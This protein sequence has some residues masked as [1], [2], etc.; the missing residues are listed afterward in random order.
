MDQKVIVRLEVICA[1]VILIA[2]F[3]PWI[4]F[5]PFSI[6]GSEMPHYR[7]ILSSWAKT[8]AG[9]EPARDFNRYAVYFI[10]FLCLAIAAISILGRVPEVRAVSLLLSAGILGCLIFVLA[11]ADLVIFRVMGLGAY[12]TIL[13]AFGLGLAALG[14]WVLPKTAPEGACPAPLPLH[15]ATP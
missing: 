6:S 5:G 10:P 4:S 8:M 13:G 1:G 14:G 15:Q 9:K 2:F 7:E 12:L 11:E 3:L